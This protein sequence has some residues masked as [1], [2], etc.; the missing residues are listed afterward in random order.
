M[1]DA[2]R[3]GD[4]GAPFL[5]AGALLSLRLQ[6]E[7]TRRKD[8]NGENEGGGASIQLSLPNLS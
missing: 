6:R 7:S 5:R 4:R 2:L 1:R 8:A 3:P